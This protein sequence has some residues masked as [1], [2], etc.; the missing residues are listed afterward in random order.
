MNQAPNIRSKKNSIQVYN[1]F[2]FHIIPKTEGE[3]AL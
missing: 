2:P 1:V 3:L